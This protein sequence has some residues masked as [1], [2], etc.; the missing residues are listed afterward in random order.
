MEQ[1]LQWAPYFSAACT[2]VFVPLVMAI[3]AGIVLV[4]F[5]AVLGGDATFK[6]VYAIVVHSGFLVALQLLFVTPLNYVRESMS[7]ATSLAVFFPMLDET[8]F[9]GMLLGAIDLFFIW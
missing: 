2:L 7:S 5:N 6:Q 8:S 4:V 9:L 3:I 1:R